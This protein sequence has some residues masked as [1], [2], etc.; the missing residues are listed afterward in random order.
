MLIRSGPRLN[1]LTAP[2]SVTMDSTRVEQV[3]TTKSLGET[4]EDK[5][6]WNCHIKKLTKKIA[7]GI[8]AMIRVRHLVPQ[9]TLHL[10]YQ[11]L[12]QPHFDY[13]STVW[14]TCGVTLQDKHKKLHN[15]AARVLTFLNYNADVGQLLEILGWKNLQLTSKR[16][17]WLSNAY[18]C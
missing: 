15:R 3:L 5:L 8:G 4:I 14:G 6:S 2:P 12:I 11:A 10:I 9:A 17:P 18:M 1:T 16:P 7:R 13:C